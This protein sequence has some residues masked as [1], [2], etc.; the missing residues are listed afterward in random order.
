MVLK[1]IL[2]CS[3]INAEFSCHFDEVYSGIFF[4]FFQNEHVNVVPSYWPFP[5]ILQGLWKLHRFSWDFL[6][7]ALP[8]KRPSIGAGIEPFAC[9]V[10]GMKTRRPMRYYVSCNP[11]FLYLDQKLLELTGIVYR[12]SVKSKPTLMV[13]EVP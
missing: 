1:M 7:P 4:H 6:D 3:R 10:Y 12:N 11:Q 13:T 2:N 5:G 8:R 9:Q